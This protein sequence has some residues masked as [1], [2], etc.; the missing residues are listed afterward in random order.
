MTR[1]ALFSFIWGCGLRAEQRPL[2][3]SAVTGKD[4][5]QIPPW[6]GVDEVQ[7]VGVVTVEGRSR[8]RETRGL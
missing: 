2:S 7:R 5:P 8:S 6:E 4:R 1:V 3:C